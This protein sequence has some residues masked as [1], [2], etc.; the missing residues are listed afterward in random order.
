LVDQPPVR[1]LVDDEMGAHVREHRYTMAVLGTLLVVLIGLL[2]RRIAGDTAGLV[3][4]AIAAATPN[5]WVNDGLV[6]SETVTGLTVVGALLAALALR[7]RPT[8]WRAALLGALCGLA[9]LA[10]AELILFLP[11]LAL[12]ACGVAAHDWGARFRLAAVAGLATLV[13]IGPWVGYNLAR[14]AEPV[15]LST[16]DGLAL[17]GSNCDPVYSGKG[18]GLTSFDA[19]AGCLDVPPP[20]GDQSE[21]ATVYRERAFD[22]M[23][24]HASRVPLVALARVGRTWSVFR[25]FD[26]IEYNTGEGRET[27][28]TRLGLAVYYPTLVLA[29][30]GSVVLWRRHERWPL[31]VLLVPAVVVTVGSAATYGQ[32]RFRAA[33]EPSL[34]VLAAVAVVAAAQAWFRSAPAVAPA[35]A[36]QPDPPVAP[37]G[38]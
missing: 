18:I 26:M 10:R 30:V 25:P 24:D 36:L 38:A 2:G 12:V 29:I 13:V 34:A 11:L 23:R 20:P 9:A 27:W 1:G 4:A 33:A 35:P 3:A 14:F 5:L 19:A 28:V 8:W 21:V 16:N 31:W 22:Y 15:F 7:A 17:S 37:A 6:M 32:T